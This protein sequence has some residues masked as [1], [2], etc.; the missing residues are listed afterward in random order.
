MAENASA[1]TDEIRRLRARVKG[2]EAELTRRDRDR[3]DKLRTTR[4]GSNSFS[5]FGRSKRDVADRVVRGVTLASTEAVR[6]F[7]DSFASFAGNAIGRNEGREGERRSVRDTALRPPSD[8]G[9][10][11]ADAVDLFVDIPRRALGSDFKLYRKGDQ[12]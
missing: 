8:I 4:R 3:D 1:A 12:D 11:I 5:D 6:L 10:S 9:A 7:T 2:L